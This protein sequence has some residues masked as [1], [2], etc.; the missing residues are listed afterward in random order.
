[1]QRMN[2]YEDEVITHKLKILKHGTN[3]D[4]VTVYI[5]VDVAN[6]I[7]EAQ[8]GNIDIH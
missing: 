7:Y 4:T 5:Q 2:V 1:M 8:Y 3:E 6:D